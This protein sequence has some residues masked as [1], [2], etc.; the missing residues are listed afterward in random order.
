M[1]KLITKII[2]FRLKPSLPKIISPSQA[3]FLANRKAVDHAI[4]IQ[5]FIAYFI[6]MKGKQG[7]MILKIDLEKAFYRLEWSF[8]KDAL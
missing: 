3:S 6:K 2:V 8:I 1:Y 5:K 4:I 7:N